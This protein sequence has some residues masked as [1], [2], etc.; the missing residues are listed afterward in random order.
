VTPIGELLGRDAARRVVRDVLGDPDRL[1]GACV[2]RE[3]R[4]GEVGVDAVSVVYSHAVSISWRYAQARVMW[5]CARAVAEGHGARRRDRPI[6]VPLQ[7]G[8]EHAPVE[9]AGLARVRALAERRVAHVVLVLAVLA[10][11]Q[12]RRDTTGACRRAA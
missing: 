3:H 5:L 8:L 12:L 2:H 11:E 4:L 10:V 9:L 7:L 1:A 6:V